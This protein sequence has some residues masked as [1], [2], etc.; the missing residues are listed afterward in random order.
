MNDLIENEK[1]IKS[2]KEQIAANAKTTLEFNL[3]RRELEN[4]IHALETI[5]Q[6]QALIQN[7]RC[8]D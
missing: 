4:E 6:T 7:N 2:F 5:A 1:K 3:L 8:N